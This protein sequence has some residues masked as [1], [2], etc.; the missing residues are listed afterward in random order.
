MNTED[1]CI[2][3][4]CEHFIQWE[5]TDVDGQPYPCSSCKLIGQSYRIEK[6]ADNCPYKD[7]FTL[8]K[9]DD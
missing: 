4:D 9:Q 6:L 5:F 1:Y 8:P 3:M 2:E 7:K